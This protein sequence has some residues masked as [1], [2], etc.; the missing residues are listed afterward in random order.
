MSFCES[1]QGSFWTQILQVTY[2]NKFGEIDE[3][4]CKE[5]LAMH[6]CFIGL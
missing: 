1:S 5:G 3:S 4:E 6:V 2:M